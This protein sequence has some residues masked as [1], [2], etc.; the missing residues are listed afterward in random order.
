MPE[1]FQE[2]LKE[3]RKAKENFDQGQISAGEFEEKSKKLNEA[4]DKQEKTNQEMLQKQVAQEN[5]M[6]EIKEANEKLE[7]SLI[8]MSDSSQGSNKVDYKQTKEF[9]LFKAGIKANNFEEYREE[10]KALN[11]TDI[12]V[13]GGYLV[14][15]TMSDEIIKKITEISPMR[16]LARTTLID[17]KSIDIPTRTQ[18]LTASYEGET[19][20]NEKST[21]KYGSEMLTPYALSVAV[22]VTWDMLM[23]ATNFEDEVMSDVVEA[24]AFSEGYNFLNGD[25]VKK[26]EGILSNSAVVAQALES[27][28][29][30]GIEFDDTINVTGR[31]K[32][33][34]NGIYTF[35]RTT[36]AYLRTLKGEDGHYLWQV[37]GDGQFNTLNGFRYM[38]DNQLPNIAAGAIPMLFGDFFKGYR[39]VDRTDMMMIRDEFTEAGKRIVNLHF[40]K[41][42]TGKVALAEAIQSIKVKA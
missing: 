3:L 1:E 13:D 22:P 39:I 37:Q 23:N 36:N 12:N 27:T 15:T 25:G 32:S 24:F 11:R 42:N 26:P 19:E 34:Y 6:K 29:S 35:N 28:L 31:L 20:S 17:T 5:E 30:G 7:K 14:P 10:M 2:A 40:H 18:L 16:S 4:L 38:I 33:G 41:W 8:K 21:S 9:Q